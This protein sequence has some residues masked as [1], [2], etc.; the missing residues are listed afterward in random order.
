MI[1]RL[2]VGIPDVGISEIEWPSSCG[3]RSDEMSECSWWCSKS[4][5]GDQS[6]EDTLDK[7]AA[8]EGSEQ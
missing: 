3:R 6:I 2:E 1:N 7:E 4:K 8:V 5:R